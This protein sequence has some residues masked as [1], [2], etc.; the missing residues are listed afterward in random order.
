LPNYISSYIFPA[1]NIFEEEG[2]EEDDEETTE[3]EKETK[4][5][6]PN[7]LIRNVVDPF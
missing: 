4:I 2:E 3:I 1:A 6:N 7:P 5:P